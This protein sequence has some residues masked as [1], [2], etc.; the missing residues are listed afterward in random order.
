MDTFVWRRE[1]QY[2]GQHLASLHRETE[3]L[4]VWQ[5]QMQVQR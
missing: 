1:H 3:A 5:E 4:Q 2:S